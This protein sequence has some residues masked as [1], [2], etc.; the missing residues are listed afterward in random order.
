MNLKNH[1]IS[2][3]EFRTLHPETIVSASDVYFTSLANKILRTLQNDKLVAKEFNEDFLRQ[4]ALK[5]AAYF[6]DVV[7]QW[8]LFYGFRKLHLQM[9]GKKLP[10]YTLDEEYLDDEINL[11]DIRFLVWTTM[12][13]HFNKKEDNRFL[14]PENPGIAFVSKLIFEI[15]EDEYETAPENE[16]IRVLLHEWEYNNFFSFRELLKWLCYNSY[17]STNHAQ[18]ALNDMKIAAR[19]NQKK[20]S[21]LPADNLI[22]LIESNAIFKYVCTPLSVKAIEWFRAITED[23]N[24]LKKIENFDCRTFQN[25]KIMGSN[26]DIIN[27][28]PFG[29]NETMLQ[30]ARNSFNVFDKN[31]TREFQT[32]KEVIRATL[33]FFDGLWQVNGLS[34]FMGM[35]EQIQTKEDNKNTTQKQHT[36]NVEHSHNAILKY[37]KNAPI[38]FFKNCDEWKK[39]WLGAFPKTPN[40]DEYFRNNPFKNEH[41]IL[42]FSSPKNGALILPATATLIK[43]PGNKLYNSE[44]AKQNGISLLSGSFPVPLKLLEFII[45]NDYIPDACINSLKGAEHGR[46]L[47]QDNKW[48]ITRFFQPNLF[49]SN[50]FEGLQTDKEDFD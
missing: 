12:Q 3:L 9:F 16:R 37:N 23:K 25:Y 19:K 46:L 45:D 34:M 1:S 31:S 35:D 11:T 18:N 29:E 43:Y 47:V 10:F 50:I 24:I 30:L 13:E 41:N 42:L 4:F 36:E 22:Y 7:S 32:G 21:V 44:L 20:D 49:D 38:A 26:K 40:I 6:E 17:L 48:F 15:L 39:F 14:N 2:T 8:G 5:S 33:A 28:L 27:L